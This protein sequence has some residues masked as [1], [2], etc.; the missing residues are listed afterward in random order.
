MFVL[1]AGSLPSLLTVTDQANQC[2]S[3]K[4]VDSMWSVF[5]FYT[6]TPTYKHLG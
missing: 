3:V 2:K 4:L 1:T 5:V 6:P